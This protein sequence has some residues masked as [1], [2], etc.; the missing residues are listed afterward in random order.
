MTGRNHKLPDTH[1]F[2]GW[3][4][5]NWC[6]YHVW[7]SKPGRSLMRDHLAATHPETPVPSS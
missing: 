6:G 2:G 1:S 5:C 4:V 3:L 7:G